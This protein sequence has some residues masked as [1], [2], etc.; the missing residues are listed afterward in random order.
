M[1]PHPSVARLLA[2]AFILLIILK[3][4]MFYWIAGRFFAMMLS[5]CTL[6]MCERENAFLREFCGNVV[7]ICFMEKWDAMQAEFKKNTLWNAGICLALTILLAVV[8]DNSPDFYIDDYQS[9]FLPVCMDIG[10][11]LDSGEYPLVSPYSWVGGAI[12][13]NFQFGIFNIVHIPIIYGLYKIGLDPVGFAKYLTLVYLFILCLGIAWLSDYYRLSVWAKVLAI[14]IGSMNYF[15]LYWSGFDWA[16]GLASF[17]W[18]PWCWGALA[19][20]V[21]EKKIR[22]IVSSGLGIYL[23]ISLGYPYTIL[24]LALVAL[25]LCLQCLQKK[26]RTIKIAQLALAWVLGVGL[27]MPAILLFIEYYAHSARA[28]EVD[29]LSTVWTVP[30]E[31][32]WGL[33]NPLYISIWNM[34]GAF[35][36]YYSFE[37]FSGLVPPVVLI[38][39]ACHPTLRKQSRLGFELLLLALVCLFLILPSGTVGYRWSFRWLPLYGLI[40][41][42]IAAKTFDVLERT[43]HDS[44]NIIIFGYRV[45]AV[46]LCTIMSISLFLYQ[47]IVMGYVVLTKARG[48]YAVSVMTGFL[49]WHILLT[50]RGKFGGTVRVAPVL[51]TIVLLATV[52]IAKVD[53]KVVQKWH[54]LNC[55]D[56]A[57]LRFDSKTRYVSLFSQQDFLSQNSVYT[58]MPGNTPMLA[59]VYSVSGYASMMPGNLY[60]LF[61]FEY[62]GAMPQVVMDATC[63][64]AFATGGM[65]DLLG[66]DGVV[67][68]FSQRER[69]GQ[70]VA[71]G[72][73]IV[74][75]GASGVILHRAR[76]NDMHIESAS[77]ATYKNSDA[78]VVRALREKSD[79][80]RR[81]VLLDADGGRPSREA[82]FAPVSIEHPVV[83]RNSLAA[84]I[85][86]ASQETPGLIIFKRAWYPGYRVFLN[87][88]ELPVVHADMLLPAV[89]IPPGQ[90]GRLLLD[91]A[92]A[93]LRIG[94]I[95]AGC[96]LLLL[97]GIV[98]YGMKGKAART[99]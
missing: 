42:I 95:V 40:V 27:S 57:N 73:N 50:R 19:R 18:L 80:A 94:L 2:P 78:D 45:S 77:L 7:G 97:L 64:N 25:W 49:L 24:M 82:A 14:S 20:V 68:G 52:N 90:S 76:R 91:F 13:G 70:A 56:V 1:L 3:C 22:W 12:A 69:A 29:S 21:S 79:S 31:A 87:D 59:K 36:R 30:P 10:R 72:W 32:F 23:V 63:K 86:N 54:G 60:R 41:A 48:L 55:F 5:R 9:A 62:S 66:I 11:S 85:A 44:Y 96:S 74:S 6:R 99:A 89:V 8:I 28:N 15:V 71:E 43:R 98:A 37:L 46:M 35:Q 51:M 58:I 65:F 81:H 93:S 26:D 47:Y 84:D 38:L 39:L 16:I 88:R 17:A 34:W 61:G 92:P 67:F 4:V 83:K 53:K 33:L 75:E